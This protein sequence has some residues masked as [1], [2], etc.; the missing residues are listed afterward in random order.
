M[1]A[2]TT[3]VTTIN[4]QAPPLSLRKGSCPLNGVGQR[5]INDSHTDWIVLERGNASQG[6]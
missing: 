4:G 1:L 5:F 6:K 3:F 2:H